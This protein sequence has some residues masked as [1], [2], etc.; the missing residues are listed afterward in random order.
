[1]V[2][3][4][5]VCEQLQATPPNDH[6]REALERRTVAERDQHVAQLGALR[7][8]RRKRKRQRQRQKRRRRRKKRK[9]KRRMEMQERRKKKRIRGKK[10]DNMGSEVKKEKEE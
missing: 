8:K 3:K 9:R 5:C 1:M 4:T 2:F 7:E 6:H 10:K